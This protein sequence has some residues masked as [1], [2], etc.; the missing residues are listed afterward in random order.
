M[1]GNAGGLSATQ[2]PVRGSRAA[3]HDVLGVKDDPQAATQGELLETEE[4]GPRGKAHDG[5]RLGFPSRS[6]MAQPHLR[7]VPV[8][9]RMHRCTQVRE[10]C[11]DGSSLRKT[12]VDEDGRQGA[13]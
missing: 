10:A 3:V 11:A 4:G 9:Q 8:G 1:R 13:R 5:N 2:H 7:D 12:G 6:D